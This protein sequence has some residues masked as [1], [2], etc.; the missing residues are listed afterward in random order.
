MTQPLP[1]LPLLPADRACGARF[2][3][4][5]GF[6]EYR[7]ELS[8]EKGQRGRKD[9]RKK[10]GNGGAGGNTGKQEIRGSAAPLLPVLPIIPSLHQ[11]AGQAPAHSVREIRIALSGPAQMVPYVVGKLPLPKIALKVIL[12][13]S[14]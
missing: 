4:D 13:L 2:S 3:C 8:R 10:D 1:S 12:D 6:A 11:D 7:N 9:R 14:S 5:G